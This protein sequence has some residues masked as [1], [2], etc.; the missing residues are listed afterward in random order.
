M[1][2]VEFA[3]LSPIMLLILAAIVDLGALIHTRMEIETAL[4]AA[5]AYALVNADSVSSERAEALGA[6]LTQL[7]V[8]R[9]GGDISAV[10]EINNGSRHLY[11]PG[12]ATAQ[13]GS[14]WQAGQCY[15]SAPGAGGV[16]LSAQSCG[17][18]CSGGST[19]GRYVTLTVRKPYTPLFFDYGLLADG[20]AAGTAIARVD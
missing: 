14:A 18:P 15:C 13:S 5:T 17:A 19:A 1:S 10:V 20:H 7:L 8:S 3:L 6:G 4:N 16:V 11:Q 12:Q 2:A 9:L